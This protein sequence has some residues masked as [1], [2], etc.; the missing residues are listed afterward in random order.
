[1]RIAVPA[2]HTPQPNVIG[3]GVVVITLDPKM[4]HALRALTTKEAIIVGRD[5]D[6]E[7]DRARTIVSKELSTVRKP[8]AVHPASIHPGCD[9][10][11]RHLR[12]EP[13][14]LLGRVERWGL[15]TVRSSEV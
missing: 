10:G 3:Q 1:M 8:K 2:I 7:R 4:L 14:M 13:A 9:N 5:R 6:A 12:R 11:P 15:E